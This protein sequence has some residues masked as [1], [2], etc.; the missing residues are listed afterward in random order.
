M[1]HYIEI[2][3]LPD[4]EFPETVLINAL[5]A[6][7]HRTLVEAGQ[8]GLGISFPDAKKNLGGKLRLH[9]NVKALERF[10]EINWR[11]GLTDYTE[12]TP[13][14][15]VPANC[16]YR[17]VSRVQAKSSSERLYRRSVKKGWLTTEEA[18]TKINESKVQRLRQPFVQLKSLSTGQSFRLFIEQ[19]ELLDS[20]QEGQFSAYGLS[21]SATVPWF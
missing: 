11:K 1:E 4:P 16:R 3:L 10:N 12:V 21:C 5:F 14:T 2:R 13:I 19:G 9:G 18:Q 20:P 6:K 8:G 15:P 7:L 17:I